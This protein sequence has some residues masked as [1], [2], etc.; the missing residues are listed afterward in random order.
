MYQVS[1]NSLK[2]L[3]CYLIYLYTS[4]NS[5]KAVFVFLIA[6]FNPYLN[7]VRSSVCFYLVIKP[8]VSV[9]GLYALYCTCKT[10]A[11]FSN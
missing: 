7:Y 10:L 4:L 9:K 6:S 2:S 5:P 8:H 1:R 11:M 3:L